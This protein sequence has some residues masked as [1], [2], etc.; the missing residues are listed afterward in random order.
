MVNSNI[1]KD[2]KFY[3]NDSYFRGCIALKEQICRKQKCIFYKKEE[4]KKNGKR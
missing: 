2:C 1:K 3:K 4:G